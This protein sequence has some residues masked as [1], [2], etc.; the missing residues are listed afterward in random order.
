MMSACAIRACP[1]AVALRRV[2]PGRRDSKAGHAVLRPFLRPKRATPRRAVIAEEAADDE[3]EIALSESFDDDDLPFDLDEYKA[4]VKLLVT[5]LE[6]DWVNPWQTK[7]AQRSTG[8]GAVIRRDADG[9]GLI[10]TA[11]HVIANSTYI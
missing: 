3:A 10:L 1:G 7:T 9:G 5:F 8:S 6:P 11:A 2:A 4:V